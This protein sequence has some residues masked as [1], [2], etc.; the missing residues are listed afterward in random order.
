MGK[1]KITRFL[2]SESE[3]ELNSYNRF[4]KRRRILEVH[5]S[6]EEEEVIENENLQNSIFKEGFREHRSG[7]YIQKIRKIKRNSGKRYDTQSGKIIP[8]KVFQN[9]D[10]QCRKDCL[11]NLNETE[12]KRIFEM[13]WNLGDFNKQNILLYEATGRSVVKR[14]RQRNGKGSCRNE[15]FTYWLNSKTGKVAVCKKFFLDTFQISEGRL[16]RVLKSKNVGN[17][18]RGRLPGSSRK[19]C[20]EANMI[21][22]NHINSFPKFESHYTRDHNPDRKYLHPDL[23]IKKMFNLYELHCEENNLK[24]V[25]EWTYRKIF[26]KDFNL[27]FHQPRKDTCQRCDLLNIKVKASENHEEQKK[28]MEEHDIHLKLAESARNALKQDQERVSSNPSHYFGFSFD[29][30]KAL[31]LPKLTTSVAY[32]KCNMYILNLGIH[33]F[34]NDN[35][36]MYVWDETKASRGSQ[37]VAS[38]LLRH[39]KTL[40][41][42]KHIIA[43]S[44]MCGGQ[45]RNIKISLMWLKI[46]S[47]GNDV[48][49]IDHK[50]LISGHS[51]LP[52]DRDFGVIEMSLKRNQLLYV[53][54][55]YYNIIKKCRKGNTFILNEMKQEDFISTRLLEEA[56]YKRSK[57]TN[58]EKINWLQICWMRFLRNEPYK[59]LYKTTMDEN[60]EFKILDLLPRR[61]RP[62]KFGNIVLPSLYKSIRSITS[63][64]YRHMMDLLRYI[65]PEHHNY[66]KSLPHTENVNE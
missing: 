27:H 65:P 2:D 6:T 13:F 24:A 28:L 32:Y 20:D 1:D 52:N 18:L 44:D 11:K 22:Q 3:E 56:V 7:T 34:H 21:V 33:N 42:E 36:Y 48:E 63:L 61:G 57:N 15:S 49:I 64:K 46:L 17:D 39:L 31:P 23:T 40:K 12:R 54:Q 38:C 41:G 25:N 66:F 62:K 5:S 30:Q 19:I 55:D 4:K 60:A 37:E 9:E 26:K 45:N 35:V 10:C 47:M 14:R 51:F 59:I 16:K 53:P 50:F 8:A 29:L 58:G 43:Y